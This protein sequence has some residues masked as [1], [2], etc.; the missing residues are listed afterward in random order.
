M[1][2]GMETAGNSPPPRIPETNVQTTC[3]SSFDFDAWARLAQ[4]DAESFEQQR[5]EIIEQFIAEAPPH[6]QKRL[7][8]VQWRIDVERSRYKHPL[9]SCAMIFS[10]MWDSV[11]S[12][13]GLLPALRALSDPLAESSLKNALVPA[14][15]LPFRR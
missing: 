1:P 4:E 2:A 10:M 3:D 13:N 15:V 7:Q 12:E 8:G 9:K 14:R 11:Y 5:R 6:L